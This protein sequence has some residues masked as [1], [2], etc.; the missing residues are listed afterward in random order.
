MKD[1][2]FDN[3]LFYN[4]TYKGLKILSVF[5]KIF[6]VFFIIGIV[7]AKFHFTELFKSKF[8]QFASVIKI[9][10]AFLLIYRFNPYRKYK[11][12]YTDLDRKISY[13]TGM[14]LIIITFSELIVYYSDAIHHIVSPYTTQVVN[15]FYNTWISFQVGIPRQQSL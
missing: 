15:T 9:I 2:L 13:S 3:S 6:V 7:Y 8:T 10:V 5:S 14:F 1:W 12:K 4:Y 11:I